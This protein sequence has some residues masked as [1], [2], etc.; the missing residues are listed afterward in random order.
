M[1]KIAIIGA[2]LL[3]RVTALSLFEESLDT[4]PGKS[5]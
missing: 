5:A 4:G 3:G 2:G 1:K